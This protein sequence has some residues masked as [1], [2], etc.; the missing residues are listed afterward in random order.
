MRCAKVFKNHDILK[1]KLS[2]AELAC[3]RVS[4][5][6]PTASWNVDWHKTYLFKCSDSD[7]KS[8]FF[9]S[10][11]AVM[12]PRPRRPPAATALDSDSARDP[13]C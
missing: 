2:Q 7:C 10:L 1:F 8:Q 5:P 9:S 4:L 12:A 11:A 6:S 3:V 13:A